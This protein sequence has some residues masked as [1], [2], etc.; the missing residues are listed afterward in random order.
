MTWSFVSG[1]PGAAI[2]CSMR[3]DGSKRSAQL[4]SARCA[5]E[6]ALTVGVEVLYRHQ[7]R[8]LIGADHERH[9][10][11]AIRIF[12]DRLVGEHIACEVL[13]RKRLLFR[14][15]LQNQPGIGNNCSKQ[16]AMIIAEIAAAERGEDCGVGG[17]E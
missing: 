7:R 2:W 17:F 12:A 4:R 9:G 8:L 16:L 1:W 14:A 11:R 5:A 6:R 15:Q 3:A 10:T 13:Q